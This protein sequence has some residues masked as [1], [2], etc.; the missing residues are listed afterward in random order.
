MVARVAFRI[1]GSP[2]L[3]GYTCCFD[4]DALNLAGYTCSSGSDAL[5]LSV[6]HLDRS[7]AGRTLLCGA[8]TCSIPKG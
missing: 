8:L 2:K 1:E 4:S 7:A 3:A 5:N 6:L